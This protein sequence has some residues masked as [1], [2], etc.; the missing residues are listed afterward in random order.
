M[1]LGPCLLHEHAPD[2]TV[3]VLATPMDLLPIHIGLNWNI[4]IDDDR[5]L[6]A[7]DEKCDAIDSTLHTHHFKAILDSAW[8]LSAST[9]SA[10]EVAIA[11]ATL[12]DVLWLY[13]I[14]EDHVPLR[15]QI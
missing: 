3:S 2:F 9:Q 4:V 7:V 15:I 14:I 1:S 5:G 12:K 10:K 13:V 8:I 6:N 11:N